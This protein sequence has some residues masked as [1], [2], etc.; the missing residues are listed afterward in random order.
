MAKRRKDPLLEALREGRS[1]T[2]TVPEGGNLASMRKAIKHGQ[3]LTMSPITNLVEPQVGDLVLVKWH[4]GDIFHIVGAIQNN[5]YLIVNSLGKVNGWVGRQEILGKI[6]DVLEPEPRP[7]VPALLEQLDGIYL[8]FIEQE[9]LAF[10][11]GQR[12][13]FIVDDLQWYA[14]RIGTE[15]WDVMP[16]DNVW[17]FHQNLWR[18]VR[19]SKTSLEKEE[20]NVDKLIDNG[21][22]CV[23][24]A[25][26]IVQKFI[27]DGQGTG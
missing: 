26:E 3:T 15:Q 5:Q 16:R 24:W 6:T 25:C 4:E 14:K 17:S 23:G 19:Q 20:H 11:D 2:W 22:R 18:L 7:A 8:A 27:A 1:Y 9:Q 13:L 12:L 21:K 10:E